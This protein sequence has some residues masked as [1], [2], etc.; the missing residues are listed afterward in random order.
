METKQSDLGE[1]TLWGTK[2]WGNIH[3]WEQSPLG[4][5]TSGNKDLGEQSPW[6]TCPLGNNKD[7]GEQ[8]PWRTCPLGNKVLGERA[9]WG[10]TKTWGNKVLGERAPWGTTKTEGNKVLGE[11]APWG[12]TKTWG[13]KVLGERAP[14]GTTKTWGNKVLGERAPWG[15]TKTWGNKVLGERA[16]WGTTKTWGNKVL[17]ERA[18][19]GTTKTWGNKVLGERAPWGTTKTWGNKVLGERAPWG[20]TKT[21][22][23]KVLGERAPWGTKSLE[24]VPLGE[25]SPWRT[26]LLGNNKDRGEHD[27][28]RT[29]GDVNFGRVGS[30]QSVHRSSMQVT[31]VDSVAEC[32]A[33][34]SGL[35]REGVVAVDTEG[36]H[37]SRTG[38]L[39]LLQVATRSAHVF[40]FDIQTNRKLMTEGGVQRL[41]ENDAI[42]KVLHSAKNDQ[43][44]LLWQHNVE[45]RNVHDTQVAHMELQKAEG[46]KFP[47]RAKLGDVCAIYCPEKA[48]L[49][50]CDKD[51]VTR[52]MNRTEGPYWAKR[53]LTQEMIDYAANDV[54]ALIPEI[55]TAQMKLLEEKGVTRAYQARLQR[56]LKAVKEPDVLEAVKREERDVMVATLKGVA[57]TSARSLRSADV[58]DQNVV[59]ALEMLRLNEVAELGLPAT[60]RDLK[61]QQM[62]AKLD[63]VE[64]D[65]KQQG[66]DYDAH[67]V[68]TLINAYV[69]V[70]DGTPLKTQAQRVLDG[71][72]KLILDDIQHKYTASTPLNHIAPYE[73]FILTRQL[74]PEG[75]HDPSMDRVLLKLYWAAKLEELEDTITRFEADRANF[76]V[77]EGFHK[78]LKFF[79]SGSVPAR[80]KQ[81][82]KWLLQT[83]QAMGKVSRPP[84][85]RRQRRQFYDDFDYDYGGVDYDFGGV[86]YDYG[87][88]DYDYGGVDYDYDYYY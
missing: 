52:K 88:V 51:V 18:P 15:T 24:N 86:D 34:V 83:L 23:N 62:K 10:T 13:N 17:G 14:W 20:T 77:S 49:V 74:R 79:V 55:Y 87:G 72:H 43:T 32:R 60:I 70:L 68:C 41:L 57:E 28:Q 6:R 25:Q 21:W 39:T 44:A 4:I 30:C 3:L 45:L 59:E 19:W 81:R 29:S 67:G 36:V 61:L 16:P 48:N 63:E 85:R 84:P 64:Q 65:M 40:L 38:P 53:P 82:G 75:E 5:Y 27:R 47:K 7:L 31:V 12:T 26:C 56:E 66:K 1:H 76:P 78:L 73:K 80:L 42:V 8:S 46:H 58:N 37:L 9:P 22:G 2:T 35:E 71:I 69:K 54:V 50:D 11:R 33:A